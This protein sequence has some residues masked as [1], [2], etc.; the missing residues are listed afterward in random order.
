[1]VSVTSVLGA[2]FCVTLRINPAVSSHLNCGR[3]MFPALRKMFYDLPEPQ[4]IS[5]NRSIELIPGEFYLSNIK[6]AG[7]Q[8]LESGFYDCKGS[9]ALF[10]L[11]NPM[12]LRLSAK[13]RSSSGTSGDLSTSLNDVLVRGVLETN[14]TGDEGNQFRHLSSSFQSLGRVSVELEGLGGAMD[15]FFSVLGSDLE[16]PA[17]TFWA[18]LLKAQIKRILG[19]VPLVPE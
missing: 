15:A 18:V 9:D 13:W 12:P 2:V 7:L 4:V 1:M 17:K 5:N 16:A 3:W 8:Y 19:G 14:S 10:E 6:L 11:K